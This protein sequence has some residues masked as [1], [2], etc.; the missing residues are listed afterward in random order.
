MAT[1][2]K[3]K[4]LNATNF[5]VSPEILHVVQEVASGD[6]NPITEL[7]YSMFI[8]L[9]FAIRNI[10]FIFFIYYSGFSSQAISESKCSLI[11]DYDSKREVNQ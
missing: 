1:V 9:R 7:I 8:V 6:L 3:V 5:F 10:Y 4:H 2:S 11:T